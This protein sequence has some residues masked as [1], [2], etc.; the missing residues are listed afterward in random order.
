M[1]I[2]SGI[3]EMSYFGTTE[4]GTIQ[5][6]ISEFGKL[7][8]SNPIIA[9]ASVLIGFWTV[10]RLIVGTLLWQYSF[11]TGTWQIVKYAFFFPISVGFIVSVFFAIRGTGGA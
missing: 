3:I 7:N 11:F 9:L 1:T 6:I 10:L 2:L 4:Q 8:F 5:S